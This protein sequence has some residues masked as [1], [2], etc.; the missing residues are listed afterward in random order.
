MSPEAPLACG[1]PR[2]ARFPVPHG[3]T[4]PRISRLAARLA[5]AD[6]A[7]R[8]MLT[9]EFWECAER[10]GTP[11]VE[12]VHDEPAH[13]A[14]TFLW[15]G[16]RATRQVLLLAEGLTDRDHLAAGLLTCLPGTEIWYLTFR[17]RADHRGSY[18]MVADISPGPRPGTVAQHHSRLRALT[19]HA[20]PD[21]LNRHVLR[22]PGPGTESSVF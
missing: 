5:T 22:G 17:L 18:R 9:A 21:P 2:G 14:V 1:T 12:A 10:E 4:S 8:T 6:P 20:A 19:A 11:L 3:A 16:H 13:R 7:E 15:R